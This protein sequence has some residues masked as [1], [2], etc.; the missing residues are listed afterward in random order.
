MLCEPVSCNLHDMKY[1]SKPICTLLRFFAMIYLHLST[2]DLIL[3]LPMRFCD[4]Q[5]HKHIKHFIFITH[6]IHTQKSFLYICIVCLGIAFKYFVICDSWQSSRQQQ[7]HH[8][9]ARFSFAFWFVPS[10]WWRERRTQ[11]KLSIICRMNK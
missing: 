10:P 5:K 7:H 4:V 2:Y 6:G 3:S 11:H 9:Q 1:R 8:Q